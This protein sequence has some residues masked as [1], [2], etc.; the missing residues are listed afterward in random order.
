MPPVN[1]EITLIVD[2]PRNK[3]NLDDLLGALGRGARVIPFVGAGLSRPFGFPEWSA[4]L[5][6]QAKEAEMEETIETR[7]A[8]GQYE[9]AGRP[10]HGP[11]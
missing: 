4:F 1:D 10:A 5:R 9:E 11:W 8:S 3:A 2:H 7:I 6:A